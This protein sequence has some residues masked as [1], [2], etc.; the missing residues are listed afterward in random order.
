MLRGTRIAIA[1]LAVLGAAGGAI[2]AT[3]STATSAT[4]TTDPA[5]TLL[6]YAHVSATGAVSD[7]SGN[8]TVTKIAAGAYCVGVTGGTVHGAVANLDSLP[9]VGGYVQTGVF[10]A[11]GCPSNVSNLLVETRRQNQ[12]GGTPGENRAFYIL[13]Y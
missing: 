9:N 13:V 7:S 1:S 12:A 5:P 4:G 6:A 3:V 8:I 11:S 10:D 2:Y